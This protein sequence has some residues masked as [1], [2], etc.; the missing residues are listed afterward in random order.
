MTNTDNIAAADARALALPPIPSRRSQGLE[1]GLPTVL[2]LAG[3]TALRDFLRPLGVT[4]FKAGLS[5]RRHVEDRIL[6]L[7]NRRYAAIVA[8][9]A[10]R[11]V[12]IVDH[13][14]GREWFLTPLPDCSGVSE[15]A[16]WLVKLPSGEFQSG[17]I[18]FRVPHSVQIASLEKRF[19][20]ILYER[21]LNTYLD[22]DEGKRRL[23]E[24]GLTPTTRLFTDYDLLGKPRRSLASELF[25]VRP[26]RE[27]AVLLQA[28]VLALQQEQTGRK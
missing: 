11:S 27:A 1:E 28:L 7:R 4:G 18:T 23:E 14:L 19:Q 15:V 21:N 16:D 12:A 9:L 3:S 25:C 2:Y 8:D 5:G 20:S 10:D 22:S 24:A 13:P 17:V 6:D 26:T